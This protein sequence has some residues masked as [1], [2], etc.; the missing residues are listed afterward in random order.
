VD[1]FSG[2]TA[3]KGNLEVVGLVVLEGAK[4]SLLK[5]FHKLPIFRQG[6]GSVHH[7]EL[8]NLVDIVEADVVMVLF[9]GGIQEHLAVVHHNLAG[10]HGPVGLVR[11]PKAAVDEVNYLIGSYGVEQGIQSVLIENRHGTTGHHNPVQQG[12][13]LGGGIETA[14]ETGCILVDGICI[15]I[16]CNELLDDAQQEDFLLCQA[17]EGK[18]EGGRIVVAV[19]LAVIDDWCA[20]SFPHVPQIPPQGGLGE[21]FVLQQLAQLLQNEIEGRVV[22]LADEAVYELE[23]VHLGIG[24]L[25]GHG[26]CSL[27]STGLSFLGVSSSSADLWA[28][29]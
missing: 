17:A 21:F 16:F 25:P 7:L 11:L 27:G 3:V 10:Q 24:F 5:G 8:V 12:N 20:K 1:P 15:G 4:P 19:L 9:I 29:L 18:V 23:S 26:S 13:V 6:K 2:N 22:L 28:M 14:D